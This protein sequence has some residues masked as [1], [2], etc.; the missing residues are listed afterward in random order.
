MECNFQESV[1]S[2]SVAEAVL[3]PWGIDIFIYTQWVYLVV[4]MG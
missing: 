3:I 2:P 4:P 1:V